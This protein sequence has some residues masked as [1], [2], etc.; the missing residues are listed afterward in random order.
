MGVESEEVAAGLDGDESAGD[1]IL[2]RH[3]LPRKRFRYSRRIDSDRKEFPAIEEVPAQDLR[4]AQDDMPVENFPGYVGFP[5]PRMD[6]P[7]HARCHH[8]WIIIPV[9]QTRQH[10]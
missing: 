8:P 4:D 10:R 3:S 5:P 7:T 2:I 6:Q 1:G 9:S